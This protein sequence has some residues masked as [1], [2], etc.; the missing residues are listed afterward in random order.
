M[1]QSLNQLLSI[2]SKSLKNITSLCCATCCIVFVLVTGSVNGFCDDSSDHWNRISGPIPMVDPSPIQLLFLQSLPDRAETY[3]KNGYSILATTAITNTLLRQDSARYYGS[4][5]DM[6]MI[7]TTLELKYGL[8]ANVEIGMSIPF[9]YTY[10]G[11]LDHSILE[12]EKIF[13]SAREFREEESN[14][15]R[16]NEFVFDVRKDGKTFI[17]GKERTSGFGDLALRVKGKLLDEGEIVPCV[18]ARFMLKIPTGDEERALGSG[19]MDYGFGL[20]LQKEMRSFFTYLNADVIIPGQAFKQADISL[21]PFVDIMMGAEYKFNEHLSGLMQLSCIS[22]PFKDTGIDMLSAV[23]WNVLL[24]LSHVTNKGVTI[25]G[26]LIQ[27][28]INADA[29]ADITYFL[30]I[31][32]N[33]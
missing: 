31:G 18:S 30:N 11:F 8:L 15:G 27:D 33:F 14:Q 13:S 9:V 6:E 16:T 26:G 32:K 12:V 7:R 5:I 3:P 21:R 2:Y 24:G 22:R 1:K 25:Q 29:G 28:T 20:L 10:G 23:I 4:M 19:A 17:G